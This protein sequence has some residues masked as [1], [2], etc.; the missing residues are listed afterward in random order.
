MLLVL[1]RRD[2]AR[3]AVEEEEEGMEGGRMGRMGV[4]NGSV[5]RGSGSGHVRTNERTNGHDK[6]VSWSAVQGVKATLSVVARVH[7]AHF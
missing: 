5:R 3:C 2:V 1:P 7:H 4:G 6:M